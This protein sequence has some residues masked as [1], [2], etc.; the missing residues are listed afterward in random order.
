MKALTIAVYGLRTVAHD[1]TKDILLNRD[2]EIVNRTYW[3]FLKSRIPS[4]LE[5]T[6]RS[7]GIKPFLERSTGSLSYGDGRT[8]FS[9]WQIRAKNPSLSKFKYEP[10]K[11]IDFSPNEQNIDLSNTVFEFYANGRPTTQVSSWLPNCGLNASLQTTTISMRA[12]E[13]DVTAPVHSHNYEHN[14]RSTG[15]YDPLSI[16]LLTLVVCITIAGVLAIIFFW[17]KGKFL[18]SDMP[19]LS[20]QAK[21]NSYW[22]WAGNSYY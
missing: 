6:D 5:S 11:H 16:T 17:R 8:G 14:E 13:P 4:S 19:C 2:V 10:I 22:S 12:A 3:R 9:L 21:V 15:F 1:N 20:R 18:H 7:Y